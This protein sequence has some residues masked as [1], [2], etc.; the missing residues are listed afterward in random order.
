MN[1]VLK[2]ELV[3]TLKF[4]VSTPFDLNRCRVGA[5][6]VIKDCLLVRE[7]NRTFY[8]LVKSLVT[9]LCFCIVLVLHVYTFYICIHVVINCCI[10]RLYKRIHL[11]V[12][13]CNN[14]LIV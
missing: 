9:H 6:D 8:C 5:E 4:G 7:K 10:R 12:R 2:V 1:N 11:H 14:E 13:H 3:L